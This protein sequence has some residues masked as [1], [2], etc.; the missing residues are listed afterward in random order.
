MRSSTSKSRQKPDALID[1][2]EQALGTV[3]LEVAEGAEHSS[4]RLKNGIKSLP[5][6][7]EGQDNLQSARAAP[8]ERQAM[9]K[10]P[11]RPAVGLN[12]GSLANNDRIARLS[13]MGAERVPE[14][15]CHTFDCCHSYM[16]RI[17][18]PWRHLRLCGK[19]T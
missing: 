19:T 4:V 1:T 12:L 6:G 14:A 17:R 7:G 13:S 2:L 3:N 16:E 15:D 8:T 9:L 18:G 11:G 5:V 10:R